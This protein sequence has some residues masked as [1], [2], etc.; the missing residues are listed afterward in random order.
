MTFASSAKHSAN[1]SDPPFLRIRPGVDSDAL[2]TIG[3]MSRYS[4]SVEKT[5]S[6]VDEE[7]RKYLQQIQFTKYEDSTDE[8]NTNK[9]SSAPSERIQAE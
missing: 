8:L 7:R 2:Q 1:N 9:Y 4:V 3:L 5:R 6:S